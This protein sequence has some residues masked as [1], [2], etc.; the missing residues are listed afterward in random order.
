MSSRSQKAPEHQNDTSVRYTALAQRRGVIRVV[1]CGNPV[2]QAVHS[3]HLPYR[4]PGKAQRQI[5]YRPGAR[6]WTIPS[7][8]SSEASEAI[9]PANAVEC[10]R[11]QNCSVLQSLGRVPVRS[12]SHPLDENAVKRFERVSFLKEKGLGRGMS[13]MRKL[14]TAEKR[15]LAHYPQILIVGADDMRRTSHHLEYSTT[16]MVSSG[17]IAERRQE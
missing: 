10:V 12:S 7:S 4:E 3:S 9:F 13:S 8:G 14:F 1:P 2:K 6:Y 16:F 11:P 15:K 17:E 5:F